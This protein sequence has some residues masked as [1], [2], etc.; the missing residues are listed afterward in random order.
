MMES[1]SEASDMAMELK[2]GQMGLNTTVIGN[3]ERL[4]ERVHLL[5]LMETATLE[6]GCTIKQTALVNTLIRTE[7]HMKGNGR[8]IYRMEKELN[9]GQTDQFMKDFTLKARS[10]EWEATNGMTDLNTLE[11]G[12]TT[13]FLELESING[14]TE[15]NIKENG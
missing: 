2:H 15:E 5:M 3:M 14:L 13:K 4:M 9:D 11:N 10:M 1:G 6:T 12:M 8:T 7:L